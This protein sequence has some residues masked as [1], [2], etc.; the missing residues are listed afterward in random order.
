MYTYILIYKIIPL[1]ERENLF[2]IVQL[3]NYF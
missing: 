1:K 2:K 3:K